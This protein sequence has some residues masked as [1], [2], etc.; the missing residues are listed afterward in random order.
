MKSIDMPPSAPAL[1]E[2][3]RAIGYTTE[4]AVADIIDNSIA[5]ESKNVSLWFG[6]APAPYFAV[7]DDGFGMNDS[8]LDLAMQYG[9][10]GPSVQRKEKDLGR[11]GLGLKTA[12]LSQ[13]RRLTIISKQGG[14]ISGRQW[15]LDEVLRTG[16][17]SLQV[18]EKKDLADVPEFS[19][20]A[21]QKC[22]TLVVW[23]S[24][25]RML[26]GE[27]SPADALSRRMTSVRKHLALVFHRYLTGEDDLD[28]VE[29]S[30]NAVALTPRDPF[31][32]EKS[33]RPMDDEI[34][35]I[36][37]K[38]VVVRPY[39]L[40]HINRMTM[41]ERAEIDGKDGLRR[42]QGFY[43][44]RNRR[45]VVWGT[46]FRMRPQDDLTKLVRIQIDIPNDLDD[47]WALDVKKSSATPPKEV[48]DHLASIVDRVTERGRKVFKA[49]GRPA[50]AKEIYIW[51]RIT[52]ADG[53]IR[54]EI[55]R[56]HPVVEQALAGSDGVN[57]DLTQLFTLLERGL[58]LHQLRL[59]FSSDKVILNSAEWSPEQIR[60]SIR[61][62][63]S[64][65]PPE[66][67]ESTLSALRLAEPYG[68]YPSVIDEFLQD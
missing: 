14:R 23:E 8:E 51:Q 7:L 5:A 9:S 10:L 55:N 1:M 59:E 35:R 15:D 52:E 39:I 26:V 54:Y 65:I 13:C 3:T 49:R 24:L 53:S 67:H 19:R 28:P 47:L 62:M 30:M 61:E 16:R 63:L 22:G 58:P 64:G 38:R 46:W 6:P 27:K 2:S 41:T 36:R 11:Y 4:A 32:L 40:P 60:D 68:N 50:R 21:K 42:S 29:I 34:L 66:L 57:R 20:L 18:L 45:L 44:Y 37:G 25:D 48:R 56:E 43:V 17:W 31:M 33:T 12:S